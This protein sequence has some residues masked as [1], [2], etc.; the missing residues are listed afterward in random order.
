MKTLKLLSVSKS[1]I[2]N[3]S[4]T[5]MKTPLLYQLYLDCGDDPV[6]E[7]VIRQVI[8]MSTARMQTFIMRNARMNK[9]LVVYKVGEVD[10]YQY[11]ADREPTF[12]VDTFYMGNDLL[13]NLANFVT[14]TLPDRKALLFEGS[15]VFINGV[16]AFNYTNFW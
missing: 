5:M 10:C 12:C 8:E 2:E 11:R 14:N 9:E 13:E 16:P 15:S 1:V 3:I 4:T 7:S 6:P